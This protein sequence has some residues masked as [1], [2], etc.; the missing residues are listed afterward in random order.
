[1]PG[2]TRT[3]CIQTGRTTRRALAA[4][5][6]LAVACAAFGPAAL[7]Q[8]DWPKHPIKIV[9]GF[10]PGG[11]ND[12]LARAYGIKLQESLKQ[13]VVI[14]NKPGAAGFIAAEQV[15]R[16]APDGYT[17]LLGPS[18]TLTFA[19]AVYSK[20]PYH[21]QN[22]FEPIA[23]LGRF[24][25]VVA[26]NADLGVKTVA[27]LVAWAKANKDKANYGSTSPA[28]Q[29]PT[30]LFKQRTGIEAV[31]IPFKGSHEK[32]AAVA[33]GQ[34]A[35]AFVDPGP[36]TA[37]VR[38]GRARV[39]ATTGAKRTAEFPDTPTM[40]EAGV[41]GIDV[42]I[43]G[44]LLAPK[45]TPRAIVERLEKEVDAAARSHEVV[46]RLK[47]LGIPVS[48]IRSAGFAKLIAEEIPLWTAV[49]KAANVKLD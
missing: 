33:S 46:D 25:L 17:L 40:A 28:F 32:M 47:G 42:Q 34:I 8:A 18:G 11:G 20:L 24:P 5:V 39:I 41:A 35:F 4:A 12:I 27:E 19:P 38:S 7:A 22:S 21:P 9:V 31:H 6:S 2:L 3:S 10:P 48:D 30:E 23:V 29:L 13:P 44:G 49:A 1:M 16:A 36:T 43:F 37:H 26:V 45:G 14:E 15:A